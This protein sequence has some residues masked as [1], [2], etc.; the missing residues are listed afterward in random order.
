[1][2][3]QEREKINKRIHEFMEPEGRWHKWMTT[4]THQGYRYYRCNCGEEKSGLVTSPKPRNPDYTRSLD[5]L[6]PVEI[7]VIE[8]YGQGKYKSAL[9]NTIIN[10]N[11]TDE[12]FVLDAPI[13]AQAIVSILKQEEVL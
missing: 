9:Y 12:L 13:R 11:C 7:K 2:N 1:M 8:A 6:R 4:A 3:D 10:E 5:L